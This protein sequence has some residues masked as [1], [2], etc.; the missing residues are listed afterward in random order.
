MSRPGRTVGLCAKSAASLLSRGPDGLRIAYSDGLGIPV[1][2]TATGSRER[3]SVDDLAASLDWSP[4]GRHL[5]VSTT[6]SGLKAMDVQTGAE[7]SVA[8]GLFTGNGKWSPDA[9]LVVFSKEG[10]LSTDGLAESSIVVVRPD[11][12]G[13]ERL[14]HGAYDSEPAWSSDGTKIYFSREPASDLVSGDATADFEKSEIYSIDLHTRSRRRLTDNDVFDRSPDPRPARR[15]LPDPPQRE[16]GA[17]VVPNLAGR[18]VRFHDE[19]R[20]LPSSA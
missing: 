7:R 9:Q 18:R 15:S 10:G 4:D 11:G 14:T 13:E 16:K 12:G 19:R 2:D 20:R 5:L 6:L 8:P 17:V 1:V 3:L